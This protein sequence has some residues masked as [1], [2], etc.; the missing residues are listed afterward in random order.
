M[1]FIAAIAELADRIGTEAI[2]S[3]VGPAR[4]VGRLNRGEVSACQP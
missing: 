2:V 1:A 3:P 4:Y